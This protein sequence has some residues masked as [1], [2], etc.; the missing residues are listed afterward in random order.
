MKSKWWI[1]GTV[2]LLCLIGGVTLVYSALHTTP[3]QNS[4]AFAEAI[5]TFFLCLGGIGVLLP[6]TL[7]VVNAIEQRRFDKIE[8]TFNLLSKWDDSHLLAARSYTR[9]I[10]KEKSKISDDELISRIEGDDSLEQSV[11]LVTNYFEHV[12][13]S[14]TNKRIDVREFKI[15]LGQT[16]IEIIDRFWPYYKTKLAA[17]CT[18]LESLKRL[19]A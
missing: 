3:P 2:A 13:F 11:I 16:L 1:F 10:K 15:S 9:K 4:S 7:N 14:I 12:R 18:D 8:S 17:A 5:K 19:L 6:I